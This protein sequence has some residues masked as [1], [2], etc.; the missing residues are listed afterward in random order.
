MPTGLLAEPQEKPASRWEAE[1][2][3][4]EQRDQRE[5]PARGGVVFIGSSS[6]KRWDLK[7]DFDGL[8]VVNHG[9][10]GSQIADAAQYV[11]RLVWPLEPRVVVLYSGDN[12][13]AS[14]KSPQQVHQD[15]RR[16]VQRVRE[17]LPECRILFLA[18]KP[19]LARWKLVD[20]I[21]EANRLI[22]SDTR[23]DQRQEY[24]DVFTPMLGEDGQPRK[25]LLVDDGLHLS[26]AGYELW[27]GVLRPHLAGLESQVPAGGGQPDR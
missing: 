14:G 27:A 19:S 16:F 24:V 6:I 22:Q 9:F 5:R 3:K 21:R 23:Q 11:E 8:P 15:Y 26:R 4:L 25:E 2:A 20:S 10:G 18:I 17:Q 1:I 7:Q 13:L 12:D